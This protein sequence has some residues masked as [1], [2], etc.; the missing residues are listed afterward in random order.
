[1]S[2][3]KRTTVAQAPQSAGESRKTSVGISLEFDRALEMVTSADIKDFMARLVQ[4]RDEARAAQRESTKVAPT[5]TQPKGGAIGQGQ[6]THRVRK[7]RKTPVKNSETTKKTT[8]PVG[9]L[10]RQPHGGALRRGNP[11]NRGGGRPSHAVKQV[12]CGD[13][14]VM[15]ERIVSRLNDP[16]LRFTDLLD[17]FGEVLSRL[18]RYGF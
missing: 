3:D 18:E 12:L 8:V 1:M 2:A 10:V 5:I 7:L 9:G 13:L 4:E 15:H 17:L 16:S 11:G 14:E 6:R